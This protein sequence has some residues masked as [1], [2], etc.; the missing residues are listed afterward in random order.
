MRMAKINV[1]KCLVAKITSHTIPPPLS[2]QRAL[3]T[4]LKCT[5][6]PCVQCSVRQEIS[7]KN[8]IKKIRG[9]FQNNKVKI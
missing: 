4:G 6:D 7:R 1:L 9:D 2:M 5:Y 3:G 8:G